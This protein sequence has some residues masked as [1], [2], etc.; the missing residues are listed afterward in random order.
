MVWQ[1]KPSQGRCALCA[2][3][4]WA[5]QMVVQIGVWEKG[6]GCSANKV[7]VLAA[8]VPVSWDEIQLADFDDEIDI[9]STIP[10][11]SKIARV[12]SLVEE[13]EVAEDEARD[14]NAEAV[15]GVCGEIC[16]ESQSRFPK[17][18]MGLSGT[19]TTISKGG[20]C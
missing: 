5:Y 1:A 16:S 8:N 10:M 4:L 20:M 12:S 7:P 9:L 15:C 6:R 2:L 19:S 11:R 18:S 3:W 17:V 13:V 14:V